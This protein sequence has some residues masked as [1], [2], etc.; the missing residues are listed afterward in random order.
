MFVVYQGETGGN[1]STAI[2]E[3]VP[4]TSGY[5]FLVDKYRR[6]YR[7]DAAL[8]SGYLLVDKGNISGLL[9]GQY[10]YLPQVVDTSANVY[11]L[12]MTEIRIIEVPDFFSN[13]VLTPADSLLLRLQTLESV[14]AGF[15]EVTAASN[16][17]SS[18]IVAIT[19]AGVVHAD[20]TDL[21]HAGKIIGISLESAGAGEQVRIQQFGLHSSN[22]LSF[23]F[24]GAAMVGTNGS[25][26]NA[27]PVGA[28]FVQFVGS[29]LAATQILIDIDNS[30][31]LL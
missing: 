3:D 6:T 26:V 16:I 10:T 2:S 8:A 31:M 4:A 23:S 22:S 5:A 11:F 24:I 18:K 1:I 13:A 12:E 29:V 9:P 19:G 15:T 27:V 14:T 28:T 7:I 17:Q 25:A 30:V 21:T 20:C